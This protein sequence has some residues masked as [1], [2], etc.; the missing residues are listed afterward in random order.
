MEPLLQQLQHSLGGPPDAASKKQRLASYAA[1]DP[2]LS[3]DDMNQHSPPG[4]DAVT[5]ANSA[6]SVTSAPL[7]QSM[8]SVNTAAAE[9]EVSPLLNGNIACNHSTNEW[10]FLKTQHQIVRAFY[11]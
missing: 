2:A 7:S 11:Q 5:S 6:G 9:E 3:S 10:N 8:D 4:L 1:S